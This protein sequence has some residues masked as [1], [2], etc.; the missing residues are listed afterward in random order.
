VAS[1]AFPAWLPSCALLLATAG[2]VSVII[3]RRVLRIANDYAREKD[4]R[5]RMA[6]YFSPAVTEHI[7]AR[8]SRPGIGATLAG[9]SA[10]GPGGHGFEAVIETRKITVLFYEILGFTAISE[11]LSGED[12]VR[13][14]NEYLSSMVDIIFAH[15]GTLDKFM[16]DGILA[17][18]GAPLDLPD[19]AQMAVRCGQAMLATLAD[20]NQT[21]RERGEAPLE[22][23][24]GVNTG[25]AILGDIGPE[26]RKE[27]TVIGDTVNVSA[28]IESLTKKI[29]SPILVS[30]ATRDACGGLFEWTAA[31]PLTVRGKAEPL[32]TFIPA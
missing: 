4:R 13:L 21:R 14:L 10:A 7:L 26:I 15:G 3:A 17:Y 2:I 23:G 28:R 11:N 30:R 12:V 20:L 24:I 1:I 5:N 31:E 29:G 16:G 6:R 25:P 18:F 27:Y 8:S 22:I 9:D 32:A 19:H